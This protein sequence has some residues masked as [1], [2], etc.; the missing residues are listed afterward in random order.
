MSNT[1]FSGRTI[2]IRL[3]R[4]HGEN[5]PT[6]Y[7]GSAWTCA[8]IGNKVIIYLNG[9]EFKCYQKSEVEYVNESS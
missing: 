3:N 1:K 6:M 7:H 5:E 9:Q 8:F 4:S 2:N